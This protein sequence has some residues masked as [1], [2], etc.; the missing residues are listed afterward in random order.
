MVPTLLLLLMLRRLGTVANLVKF[1]CAH[2]DVGLLRR[3]LL[4]QLLSPQLLLLLLGCNCETEDCLI[5]QV[6]RGRSAAAQLLLMLNL[7]LL[8]LLLSVVSGTRVEQI[9]V[10]GESKFDSRR[11]C[12]VLSLP[13]YHNGRVGLPLAVVVGLRGDDLDGAGRVAVGLSA[14][15]GG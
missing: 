10:E 15:G 8:L 5:L 6:K 13:K 1:V 2:W 7:L 9:L 11:I 14:L 12:P 3:M 4:V